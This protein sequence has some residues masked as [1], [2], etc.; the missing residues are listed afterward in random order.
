M[1]YNDGLYLN[2]E[3]WNLSF[4]DLN[5]SGL[6]KALMVRTFTIH[7]R[8]NLQFWTEKRVDLLEEIEK[9]I[10]TKKEKNIYKILLYFYHKSIKKTH[11]FKRNVNNIKFMFL[12]DFDNTIPPIIKYAQNKNIELDDIFYHLIP[13]IIFKRLLGKK[14]WKFFKENGIKFQIC[15]KIL[16]ANGNK[17]GIE[18]YLK[19]YNIEKYFNDIFACKG[20]KNKINKMK[21]FNRNSNYSYLPI[22]IDDSIKMCKIASCIGI[23]PFHFKCNK[24]NTIQLKFRG[25]NF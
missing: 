2:P 1:S 7:Y 20:E 24:T 9:Y 11:K 13:N 17:K 3:E 22:L 23:L 21:I 6:L 16:S 15:Y 25:E 10:Y 18:E 8:H 5:S 4:E 12:I 14:I 19:K